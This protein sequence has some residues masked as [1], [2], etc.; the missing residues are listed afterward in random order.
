MAIDRANGHLA[1]SRRIPRVPW[2]RT[3]P[4][5]STLIAVGVVIREW[6]R[7]PGMLAGHSCR[8]DFYRQL[9]L[10]HAIR[11]G[12]WWPRFNEIFYYGYG[13]PLF[14]FYAPLGYYMAEAPLLLGLP[15]EAAIKLAAAAGLLLSGLFAV[16]LTR[17]LFGDA[18]A[19]V[20]G[21]LYVLAPYHL[22]DLFVRHALGEGIAFAWLPLAFWG[23]VGAVRDRSLLRGTAAAVATALLLLTH[24]ISALMTAPVLLAWWLVLAARYRRHG[25]FGPFLGAAAGV[26]GA[27]WAAFQW[28]P[29]LVETDS[30]TSVESLTEGNFLFSDHFASLDQLLW[31][32][33]DW[34]VS[35]PGSADTVSFQL[36]WAHWVLLL[37]VPLAWRWRREWRFALAFAVVLVLVALVMCLPLSAPL[38]EA[39]PKLRFVQFPWRFLLLA[40]FGATLAASAAAQWAVDRLPVRTA[41]F[42]LL[43]LVALPFVC[44][45]PFAKPRF[46]TYRAEGLDRDIVNRPGRTVEGYL[47]RRHK[48]GLFL[49][50]A[51]TATALDLVG[52]LTRGTASDDFLPRHVRAI[53]SHASPVP[54]FAEGGEVLGY[55]RI[56]P[57]AYRV[58][59]R[60]ARDGTLVLRRFMF[61]G[62][63]ASIDGT[64]TPVHSF[65]D[66]G[67]V[68]VALARGDHEV[69][70][71]FGSTPLRSRAALASAVGVAAWLTLLGACV[72]RRGVSARRGRRPVA[73]G[74]TESGT[75]TATSATRG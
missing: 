21:P 31:S 54:L 40:T 69:V 15:V 70:I 43:A 65:G 51:K 53:P 25:P 71:W 29:A 74:A 58:T 26:C 14:H 47:E 44:Y 62:W 11:E 66:E 73:T 42:A 39:V 45:A 46:Y 30:V 37:G 8:V 18:A 63:T 60:M 48:D 72:R 67:A 27:L 32:K 4:Y 75:G 41:P 9:V 68:A 10:D 33:W 5:V 55:A 16:W 24:S 28:V 35:V 20:A 17:D 3:L 36:G 7:L 1:T 61:A 57:C 6:W 22:V 50:N 52:Q 64:S 19:C 49:L 13:S 12:D 59:A 34:G 2:P 56:R 23:I 38:W